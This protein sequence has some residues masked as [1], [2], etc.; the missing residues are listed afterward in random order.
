MQPRI[1]LG[2]RSYR[3]WVYYTRNSFKIIR[4]LPRGK[5][6]QKISPTS[7]F[8][9]AQSF[10]LS[11]CWWY[12]DSIWRTVSKFDTIWVSDLYIV[13][14]VSVGLDLVQLWD[15]AG[16][17]L[18]LCPSVMLTTRP[19]DLQSPPRNFESIRR[20]KLKPTSLPIISSI[21]LCTPQ[22]F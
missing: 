8:C 21:T 13:V 18:V 7:R 3:S 5:R 22:I 1:L 9:R 2:L 10:P 20:N 17:Y 16:L 11:F 12:F 6:Y 15:S 4:T 14:A 19:S